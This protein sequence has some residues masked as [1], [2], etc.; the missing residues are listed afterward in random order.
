MDD[1]STGKH[2]IGSREHCA[3][4]LLIAE[5][6]YCSPNLGYGFFVFVRRILFIYYY[7][8]GYIFN[9]RFPPTN[10]SPLFFLLKFLEA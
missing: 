1:S 3:I 8:D 2:G 10:L 6:I 9:R 5:K 4:D 7:F